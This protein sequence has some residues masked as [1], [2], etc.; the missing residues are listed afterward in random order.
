MRP[1]LPETRNNY[2]AILLRQNKKEAAAR[3]FAASLKINPN[4]SSALINLA[5]IRFAENDFRAARELFVKAEAVA[6]DAEIARALVVISLQLNEKERA[7]QEFK[8]YFSTPVAAP[9]AAL[10]ELLLIKIFCR[11]RSR[12]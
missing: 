6:P 3:E 2:G 10:G 1:D 9:D 7:A 4:Q 5:K 11:R 12:N 8:E